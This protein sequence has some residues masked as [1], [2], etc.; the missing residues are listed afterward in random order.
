M[1]WPSSSI[2]SV[3]QFAPSF[4][5]AVIMT[6]PKGSRVSAMVGRQRAAPSLSPPERLGTYLPADLARRIDALAAGLKPP[7]NRAAMVAVLVEIGLKHWT[8]EKR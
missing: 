2:E 8:S 6:P 3:I 1:S 4:E 5:T 7:S